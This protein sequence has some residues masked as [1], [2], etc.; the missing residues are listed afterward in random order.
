MNSPGDN[1]THETLV[2]KWQVDFNHQPWLPIILFLMEITPGAHRPLERTTVVK[3]V[4]SQTD[5]N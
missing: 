3:M 2:S 1:E 4:P 5:E